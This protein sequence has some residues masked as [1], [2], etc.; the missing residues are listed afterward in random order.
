MWTHHSHVLLQCVDK[1]KKC[2]YYTVDTP[3]RPV[4]IIFYFTLRRLIIAIVQQALRY[5]LAIIIISGH[6]RH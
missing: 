1:S 5:L 3:R 6:N 2:L 4:R